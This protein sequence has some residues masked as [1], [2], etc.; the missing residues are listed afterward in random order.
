MQKKMA[1]SNILIAALVAVAMASPAMAARAHGE[2]AA[3]AAPAPGGEAVV[4]PSSTPLIPLIP[5]SWLPAV[6]DLPFLR[7][8]LRLICY[9]SPAKP[10]RP[11][12]AGM[13]AL[14]AAFLTTNASVPAPPGACCEAYKAAIDYEVL[15]VCHI[16][17]GE[18]GKFLPA[19]VNMTRLFALP[20]ACGAPFDN[21]TYFSNCERRMAF[22][23]RQW[24][25]LALHLLHI[26]Q[27]VQV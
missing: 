19:P 15:C 25:I 23:C 10:C 18:I 26:R 3:A 24:M 2:A 8:I 5:C 17:N 14:C 22:L 13:A 4:Q 12:V 6:P 11:P 16:A 9:D 20:A 21:M 27:E 1:P 7:D